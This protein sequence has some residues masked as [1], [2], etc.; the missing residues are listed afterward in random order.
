MTASGGQ[1]G[2]CSDSFVVIADGTR[3]SN[4]QAPALLCRRV[5][6]ELAYRGSRAGVGGRCRERL[7]NIGRCRKDQ[8][9]SIQM[10]V[11]RIHIAL[12][13]LIQASLKPTSGHVLL[14]TYNA[15]SDRG[16]PTRDELK[17]LAK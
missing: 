10:A 13:I 6:H 3:Y 12:A 2:C 5:G 15:Q 8:R 14:K 17:G 9:R 7:H 4:V 11:F 1:R 16:R